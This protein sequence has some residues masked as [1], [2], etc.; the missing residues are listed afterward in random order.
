MKMI[1]RLPRSLSVGLLVTIFFSGSGRAVAAPTPFVR[2]GD[3]QHAWAL[4]TATLLQNGKVLVA[5]GLDGNQPPNL[6]A[7]LYDPA[8]GTFSDTGAASTYFTNATLLLDGRVLATGGNDAHTQIYDPATSAWSDTGNL[9]PSRLNCTAT[10]LPNGRVLVAGGE[11]PSG[12]SYASCVV[13]NPATAS[14]SATDS[15]HVAR[16]KHTATLLS[17]GT[18]LV[19]GGLAP[20]PSHGGTMPAPRGEIY[21]PANASWTETDF[22]NDPRAEHTATLLPDGK[23]LVAGGSDFNYLAT[24]ELFDPATMRWT[25]TGTLSES[26]RGHQAVLLPTGKVLVVTGGGSDPKYYLP[27]AE[28]YDPSSGTWTTAGDLLVARTAATATLLRDGSVLIAGGDNPGYTHTPFRAL[29]EAELYEPAHPQNVSTR[30]GVLTAEKVL[31]GGFI[32]NGASPKK[33]M[34]RAIGPSLDVAGHLSDPTLEL[35]L[36]GGGVLR[37]DDWKIDEQT[38]QSQEAAIAA[39]TIPPSNSRESALVETLPPGGYTAIVA[40]KDGG[41]G[42]GLVEIYDLDAANPTRLANISTR[43]FVGTDADVLI[44]GFIVGAD[45]KERLKTSLNSSTLLLR[46]GLTRRCS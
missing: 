32:I 31:I 38:G 25:R 37:N 9:Q 5:G 26:R 23:V 10:L 1:S 24:A 7:E 35:H 30:A 34:L 11:S 27:T 45:V 18:V 19:A 36:P 41:T 2:T 20:D 3:P 14:W 15:L 43:G 16:T 6:V 21:D 12:V 44:G 33:V 8:T 29:R 39:T 28:L 40:G 13:Y 4:Q 46:Q 17:D 22:L 42:V